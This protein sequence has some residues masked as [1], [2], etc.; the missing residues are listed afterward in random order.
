MSPIHSEDSQDLNDFPQRIDDDDI[1]IYFC[2]EFDST[3]DEF[4]LIGRCTL[5]YFSY[6]ETQALLRVCDTVTA[7]YLSRL[8]ENSRG[9]CIDDL[10]MSRARAMRSLQNYTRAT[11]FAIDSEF[12]DTRC[13]MMRMEMK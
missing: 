12:T 2:F 11:S 10:E 1:P 9:F 3:C 13:K 7:L 6:Y 4:F 8:R 5:K